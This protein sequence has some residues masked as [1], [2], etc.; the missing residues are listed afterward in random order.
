MFYRNLALKLGPNQV[1][2]S[3]FFVVVAFVFVCCVGFVVVFVVVRRP[4]LISICGQCRLR[5][6]LNVSLLNSNHACG[7]CGRTFFMECQFQIHEAH[8]ENQFI[9]IQNNQY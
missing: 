6:Q 5:I 8:H 3:S 1:N 4:D 2:K 9:I 7:V